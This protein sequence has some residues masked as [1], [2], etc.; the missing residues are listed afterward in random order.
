[1]MLMFMF[2]RHCEGPGLCEIDVYLY[3]VNKMSIFGHNLS[4]GLFTWNQIDILM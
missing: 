3:R 2:D 4:H 1:M